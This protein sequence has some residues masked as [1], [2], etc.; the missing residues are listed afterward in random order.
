LILGNDR[1]GFVG[2]MSGLPGGV[3]LLPT[4]DF[5]LNNGQ[6][7]ND[8]L[9][10][11]LPYP[12]LYLNIASPPGLTGANAHPDPAVR[13]D[14]RDRLEEMAESHEWLGTP[15]LPPGIEAWQT[16][17]DG[18]LTDVTIGFDTTG[19]PV[20][21]RETM[22]D[23]TVPRLSATAMRLTDSSRTTLKPNLSHGTACLDPRVMAWTQEIFT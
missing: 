3:Q 17:G 21:G 12:E 10:N 20:P 15:E 11:G 18:L 23:E 8:A 6:R 1:A 13:A 5:P 4:R 9:N 7:W 22:G 14:F 2:N 19:N 16:A